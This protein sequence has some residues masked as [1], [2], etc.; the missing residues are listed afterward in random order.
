MGI[1]EWVTGWKRIDPKVMSPQVIK[2]LNKKAGNTASLRRRKIGYKRHIKMGDITYRIVVPREIILEQGGG[3]LA[4]LP[5][6]YW[7]R[8]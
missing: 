5:E 3:I 6:Y 1:I 7:K 2:T 8:V 4:S